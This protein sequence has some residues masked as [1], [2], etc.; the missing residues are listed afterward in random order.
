MVV[1]SPKLG[2]LYKSLMT[3]D[4][5][6]E[7]EEEIEEIEEEEEEEEEEEG[8]Y[9]FTPYTL[10]A[11]LDVQCIMSFDKSLKDLFFFYLL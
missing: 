2:Q 1:S 4:L 5:I 3:P 7:E 11:F 6:L 9:S 8:A 10:W